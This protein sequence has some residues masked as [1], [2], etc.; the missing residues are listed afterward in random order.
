M[1]KENVG[2]SLGRRERE[3]MA[4]RREILKAAERVFVEKGFDRATMEDVAKEAEFSVGAIYNFFESK[5]ALCGEVMENIV[6]DFHAAFRTETERAENPLAAITAVVDL[7]FRQMEEHGGFFRRI[8]DSKPTGSAAPD[9]AIPKN[10]QKRYDAYLEGFA[11]LFA[12]AID[13]GQVRIMDPIYAALALE[14]A[15]NAYWAYWGRTEM[16]LPISERIEKVR[17]NCLDMV[18]KQNGY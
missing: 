4:H 10:C 13:G 17:R 9:H 5:D 16:S 3:K 14:G 6:E 2:G 18:K 8:M 7:R 15:I 1:T 12:K 11:E